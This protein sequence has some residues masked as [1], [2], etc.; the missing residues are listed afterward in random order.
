MFE[1]L[2][3]FVFCVLAISIFGSPSSA[4]NCEKLNS[5]AAL[6]DGSTVVDTN[7]K[8]LA[9]TWISEGCETRPG[10]EY[11]LRYYNFEEDGKYF[12]TQH[13][14]WDDSCSS[15]QLSVHSYGR[16]QLRNSLIQP[17]A[18]SGIFKVSNITVIPQDDSAARELDK[19]VSMECP[20]QPWKSWRK[21][22]EHTVYDS[23]YDENRKF[24]LWL[25]T[26]KT[27]NQYSV[28]SKGSNVHFSDISCLGSLKWA[29]NELK[30]LKIQL[31]PLIEQMKKVPREVKMELLLGDIHSNY[32][33]RQYYTPTSFQVPLV[34]HVKEPTQ[35]FINRHTFTIQNT[36]AIPH[37]LFSNSKTPPHLI[38]K[39]HLPPYIWGQWTSTRCESRP[40]GNLYLTRKFSFYSEDATW[41]GEH[42]FYSDPFCR[43]PKF[44]VTAAG[45]F[46]LEGLNRELRGTSNIDFQIERASLTVFDQ[47][48]IVDMSLAD[49]CGQGVWQVSVPKELS[50]TGGCFPL[51]I[52][53]P[54]MQYDIVKMEMDYRGAC[55]LYLG[56]VKT[57]LMETN[58]KSNRPSSFQL[59]LVKCGEV[60]TYSQG[61]R[62]ILNEQVYGYNKGLGVRIEPL[63]YLLGMFCYFLR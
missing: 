15:P 38:E 4:S 51:G 22:Q 49:L 5:I 3:M 6:E 28:N 41:I 50:I 33:L 19:T 36:H 23:R 30:L 29:F 63:I 54:S 46:V 21:Y 45:H 2:K 1:I 53:I 60:P 12:L 7:V 59:P 48:M 44:I 57:D 55:L 24:K 13:H 26:D 42:N 20:S 18:A 61:L 25:S 34:K 11:V 10:P 47:K 14:Y 56:Q 62:D 9:G 40:G 43:I 8:M 52:N 32:K 31:R 27:N 58:E 39:P 35:V 37:N 16:I 17:G